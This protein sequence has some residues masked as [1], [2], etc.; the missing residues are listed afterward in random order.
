MVFQKKTNRGKGATGRSET[1][2]STLDQEEKT[3]YNRHAK[4]K[5]R[6]QSTQTPKKKKQTE[7]SSDEEL[8]VKQGRP[9]LNEEA[10]TP[11]SL[12]K[13]KR[14][15][16]TCKRSAEKLSKI[17]SQ[18]V[19]KCW[20]MRVS[21]NSN[22]VDNQTVGEEH[23]ADDLPIV[24]DTIHNSTVDSSNANDSLVD[25]EQL[26][27]SDTV[28]APELSTRKK[29]RRLCQLKSVLP[30]NVVD[31]THLFIKCYDKIGT[32]ELLNQQLQCMEIPGGMLSDRQ[33]KY[34]KKKIL[35]AL[36]G[37]MQEQ[38]YCFRYWLDQII[39]HPMIEAAMNAAEID[40]SYARSFSTG[41]H[42]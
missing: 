8:E 36:K 17:R 38:T 30:N 25:V 19:N 33:L 3:A 22:T 39:A 9:P 20:N 2:H 14:D 7:F 16:M 29:L 5:S 4:R 1:D 24:N 13:R 23:E 27:C 12:R 28:A 37:N 32:D 40:I 6:G 41:T 34:R 18:A 15:E 31:S 10:M 21:L 11:R 42:C 26:E 35:H